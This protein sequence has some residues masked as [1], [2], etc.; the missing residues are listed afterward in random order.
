MEQARSP[1]RGKGWLRY[2]VAAGL[3]GAILVAVYMVRHSGGEP[4]IHQISGRTMGTT[5]NV[6]IV[7]RKDRPGSADAMQRAV[8][9][10][11]DLVNMT[12]SR[13]QKDS[14]L[15]RFNESRSTDPFPMSKTALEVLRKALKLSEL[16]GG[17]YDVTVTPLV[18]LWGFSDKKPR[19]ELPTEEEIAD[20]RSLVGWQ[21]VEVDLDAGTI[22]KTLPRMT[23]D[24]SSIAKGAAV[25]QIAG[26]LDAYKHKDYMIEVGGEVRC[27][28]KSPRGT[29]WRIGIEKPVV[30]RREI[31]EVMELDD[32][33][34]ATS[35]DYRSYYDL[36]GKRLSHTIDPRTGRPVEHGLASVTVIHKSCAVA[37]GLATA[38][39][40][41][42][43]R[44]GFAMAQKEK[45]TVL[46]IERRPD[47]SL[48]EMATDG[49]E[50]L[51]KGRVRQ[52][53][54]D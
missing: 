31:Q 36:N 14:E 54:A 46:F 27:K 23:V 6:T 15:F 41:L 32:T 35:G 1:D 53:V 29:P 24:L 25:D 49:F 38:L 33:S 44:E 2:A 42:G 30:D 37:D 10:E 40:V 16:T 34:M 43:P 51:R 13:Y 52:A 11:L 26:A 9:G 48:V 47:G 3:V 22:S 7:D 20:A 45:L 4:R 50:E 5:Y 39:T 19:T 18:K 17:A 12:M 21:K 8:V 28:G